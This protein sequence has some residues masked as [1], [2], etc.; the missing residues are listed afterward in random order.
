MFK[1]TL[2]QWFVFKTIVEQNGFSAAAEVLNRSQSTISY[3][4][5]KLQ[6]QLNVQLLQIEGKRCELTPAGRNLLQTV[7][8]LLEDF[9][10]LEKTA[11]FLANGIEAKI[12]INI[13]NIFPKDIL[14]QA[15]TYFNEKYPLTE[16]VID[17]HLRL[18]PSDDTD[19][20]LAITT[21]EDGLIPG[22]KLLEI[23]LVPV[24]HHAHPIFQSAS[25]R[26]SYEQLS[27]YKQIFY[28]RSITPGRGEI[29]AT[30]RKYWSVHSVDA[31][32]AAVKANLCYGW[33]P[34]HTIGDLLKTGLLKEIDIDGN[35]QC[36]IPL[37]LV[38][39]NNKAKGPATRYLAEMIKRCCRS[40]SHRIGCTSIEIL[41]LIQR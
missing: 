13:D 7:Y 12:S 22:Q 16:I 6:S 20:D 25:D 24:A 38:E 29:H 17:E 9:E 18:M 37:Y 15:I 31:A 3:S 34:K 21:S 19:Y 40:D 4:M 1:T 5:A 36:D 27:H 28:Q 33:L 2:D 23:S 14:F 35:H 32:I 26:F 39:K 10:Y 11:G 30:P 8:P 41:D